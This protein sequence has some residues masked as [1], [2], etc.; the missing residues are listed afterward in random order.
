MHTDFLCID[1]WFVGYYIF[2]ETVLSETVK[3]PAVSA[4]EIC[5]HWC[6]FAFI[7]GENDLLIQRIRLNVTHGRFM[8]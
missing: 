1:G 5:A 7:R 3:P 2:Y 8:G 6:A 4:H